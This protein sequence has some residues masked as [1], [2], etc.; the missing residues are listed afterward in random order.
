M[1]KQIRNGSKYSD[2]FKATALED[3]KTS[4]LSAEKFAES[5]NFSGITMRTW[6]KA[7]GH[8]STKVKAR[9]KVVVTSPHTTAEVPKVQKDGT[10]TYQGKVFTSR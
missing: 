3:F 2:V 4:A 10:I 8:R 9:A 6:A 1:R 5:R 7:A